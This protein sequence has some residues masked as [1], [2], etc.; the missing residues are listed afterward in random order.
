M[1]ADGHPQDPHPRLGADRH[2]PGGRVRRLRRAGVQGAEGGGVRGRPRQLQPGDDHDRSGNGGPDLRGA[3]H[4]RGRGEDHCQRA[5]GR[6]PAH[7]WRP[8]G[9]EHRRRPGGVRRARRPRGR[10]DRGDG[11]GHPQGGGPG[12]I[13]AR[14]GTHRPARSP[15]R[16]RPHPG[17]GPGRG[18]PDR[19]PRHRPPVLHARRH[20]QR[21]R[22]QPRGTGRDRPG[23]ARR[24]HDPRDHA[25]SR[26]GVEEYELG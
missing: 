14:H 8:D 4:P 3:H 11:G 24:E 16:L 22:L 13:P 6:A 23:G 12:G 10:D 1:P 25:E 9:P 7:A 2:R 21:H 19:L 26:P 15:Q 20:R 17:R 18:G 5:P